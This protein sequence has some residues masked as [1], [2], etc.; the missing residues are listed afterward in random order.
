MIIGEICLD[1]TYFGLTIATIAK[2]SGVQLIPGMAPIDDV[3]PIIGGIAIIL[4]GAF[5][6][7]EFISNFFSKYINFI[8]KRMGITPKS[9]SGFL[10]T[11]ANSIA[12]YDML[13]NMDDKGKMRLGLWLFSSMT[14]NF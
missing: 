1:I 10:A 14:L 2:L 13:K 9:F 4:G 12:T 6:M 7:V 11:T 8:S 3:F 5:P